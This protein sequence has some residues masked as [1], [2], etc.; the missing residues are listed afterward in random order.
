MPMGVIAHC[1]QAMI[2]ICRTPMA[3]AFLPQ[4]RLVPKTSR[5]CTHSTNNCAKSDQK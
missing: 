1:S 3:Y 2:Q 5:Y 4:A